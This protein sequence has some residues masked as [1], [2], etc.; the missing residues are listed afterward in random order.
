MLTRNQTCAL[1]AV[2]LCCLSPAL[3]PA[4]EAQKA[5]VLRPAQQFT[6]PCTQ[7]GRAPRFSLLESDQDDTPRC[8]TFGG[9]EDRAALDLDA[10]LTMLHGSERD[11]GRLQW[12]LGNAGLLLSGDASLVANCDKELDRLAAAFTRPIAVTAWLLPENGDPL[13]SVLDPQALAALLKDGKLLWTQT[14]RTQPFGTVTLANERWTSYVSDV[15]VEVAQKAQIGDPKLD[16]LLDGIRV[17]CAVEPLPDGDQLVLD[18]GLGYGEKVA[19]ATVATGV[20]DQPDIELPEWRTALAQGSARIQNG[21]AVVLQLRAQEGAGPSC[22]VLLSARFLAPPVAPVGGGLLFV[23]VGA[24][25]HTTP[26]PSI[27]SLPHTP[28]NDNPHPAYEPTAAAPFEAG[29]LGLFLQRSAGDDLDY[30]VQAGFLVLKGEPAQQDR[31]MA[32]LQRL[33]TSRL[34]N[35]ELQIETRGAT[36]ETSSGE[37]MPNAR[38]PYAMVWRMVLP[39]L[40]CRPGSGFVGT[41]FKTITDFEVEIAQSAGVNNPVERVH[42][43]GLWSA[44]CLRPQGQGVYADWLGMVASQGPSRLHPLGGKPDGQLGMVDARIAAFPLQGEIES[45]QEIDLG[46]GPVVAIGEQRLRTRQF[47]RLLRR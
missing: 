14:T 43:S 30:S 16:V 46:D 41:E 2:T 11:A 15:D 23:P 45:G 40:A 31:V 26:P 38:P 5:V 17:S 47:V 34:Q 8:L 3:A 7:L 33:A 1:V 39:V 13:P 32:A 27:P 10:L 37:L 29:D 42:Q 22:R 20:K 9:F 12:D 25:L 19:V 36:A 21:G 18:L 4:Q 28:G 35:V 24:L 6:R 44:V